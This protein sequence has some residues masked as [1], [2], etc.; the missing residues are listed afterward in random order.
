MADGKSKDACV[1]SSG[2]KRRIDL[3][4]EAELVTWGEWIKRTSDAAARS[5]SDE[6]R[7][8]LRLIVTLR[9]GRRFRVAR[10]EC[11]TQTVEGEDNGKPVKLTVVTGYIFM[12][13]YWGDTDSEQ[14]VSIVAPP[15]MISTVEWMEIPEEEERSFGFAALLERAKGYEE[16]EDDKPAIAAVQTS[17]GGVD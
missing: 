5:L 14:L 3:G 6:E 7:E 15:Y 4:R 13:H 12:G 10:T 17:L 1:E 11:H 8:H 2:E 9:D 16:I